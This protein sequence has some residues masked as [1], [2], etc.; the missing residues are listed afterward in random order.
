MISHWTWSDIGPRTRQEDA[1]LITDLSNAWILA[2]VADGIGGHPHGDQAAPMAL[3][4]L[5]TLVQAFVPPDVLDESAWFSVLQHQAVS[6]HATLRHAFPDDD[7]S[8][9]TTALWV[10]ACSDRVWVGHIGDSRLTLVSPDGSVRPLT[11]DMTPAGDRV[12]HGQAPWEHQNTAPDAHILTSCLGAEFTRLHR[13]S[14]DWDPG[15]TLVLATD[16]L[17]GLP[18]TA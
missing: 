13:F 4:T 17:N 10:F 5:Q 18:L 8:P 6:M 3:K 14:V 12:A 16:G 2:A 9:G 7:P 11:L 1:T 15:D